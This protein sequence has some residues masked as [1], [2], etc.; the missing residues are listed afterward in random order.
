MFNVFLDV[1]LGIF[2]VFSLALIFV[3]LYQRFFDRDVKPIKKFKTKKLGEYT[4]R[5][6]NIEDKNKK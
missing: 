3:V 1:I 2:I 5:Y 4:Y 6:Y